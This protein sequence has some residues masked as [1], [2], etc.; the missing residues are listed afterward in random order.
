[1]T[2]NTDPSTTPQPALEAHGLA[3]EILRNA[4]IDEH[5]QQQPQQ[6]PIPQPQM[7]QDLW[8][9]QMWTQPQWQQPQQQPQWQQPQQQPQWQQP[10][11]A[12]APTQQEADRFKVFADHTELA[13][14]AGVTE[15]EMSTYSDAMPLLHKLMK[16]QFAPMA[17]EITRLREANQAMNN[18]SEHDFINRVRGAL[19]GSMERMTN[20]PRWGQFLN[21]RV[22]GTPF[23]YGDSLSH[24]H[25]SRD[26]DSVLSTFRQFATMTGTQP[27]QPPAAPM[28]FQQQPAQP[29]APN[30]FQ[31]PNVQRMTTPATNSNNTSASG[32]TKQPTLKWSVYDEARQEY[33]AGRL[34]RDQFQRVKAMYDPAIDEGRVNFDA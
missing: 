19:N 27:A 15:D 17:E 26:L 6:P 4:I 3:D 28:P 2:L 12:P 33:V 9:N 29:T 31:P 30:P 14:A 23:T 13:K 18:S 5:Q 25:G 1:M 22:A 16:A 24:A 34:P 7:P 32:A 10:Q 8:G 11:Q 20:D 21:M